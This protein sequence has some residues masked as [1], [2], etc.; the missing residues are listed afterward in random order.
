MAPGQQQSLRGR[1]FSCLC[2]LDVAGG[3]EWPVLLPGTPLGEVWELGAGQV[4][5]LA[6]HL[7]Q[8]VSNLFVV[9]EPFSQVESCLEP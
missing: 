2:R 1:G 9:A 6:R 4:G 8:R 3:L 7:W 5:G